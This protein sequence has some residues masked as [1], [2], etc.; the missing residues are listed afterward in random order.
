MSERSR[1]ECEGQCRTAPTGLQP[2]AERA[3]CSSAGSPQKAPTLARFDVDEGGGGGSVR[4]R[5]RVELVKDAVLQGPS[6]A[7]ARKRRHD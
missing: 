4:H 2:A 1:G 5:Q 7:G 3:A 6:A